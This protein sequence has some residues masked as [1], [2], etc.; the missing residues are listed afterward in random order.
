MG[1]VHCVTLRLGPVARQIRLFV[2][3]VRAKSVNFEEHKV[4]KN[5]KK[6]DDFYISLGLCPAPFW[7]LAFFAFFWF[8]PRGFKMGCVHL[9]NL[10]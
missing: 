6:I 8:S 2:S 1:P 3:P 5:V 9:S 10:L 4:A 7:Q